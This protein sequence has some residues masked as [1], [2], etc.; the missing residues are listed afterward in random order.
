MKIFQSLLIA[1]LVSAGFFI[2]GGD[3]FADDP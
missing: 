3:A 1:F 2:I